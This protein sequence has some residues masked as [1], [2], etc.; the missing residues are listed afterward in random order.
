MTW[1]NPEPSV[2]ESEPPHDLEDLDDPPPR[3]RRTRCGRFRSSMLRT[4]RTLRLPSR[5]GGPLK[6][7][8]Q[9][10]S[11]EDSRRSAT[12]VDWSRRSKTAL[13]LRA[14][15][16]ALLLVRPLLSTAWLLWLLPPLLLPLRLL[17]APPLSRLMV[18]LRARLERTWRMEVLWTLT[19]DSSSEE[20]EGGRK[21]MDGRFFAELRMPPSSSVSDMVPCDEE[22]GLCSTNF[23]VIHD[24]SSTQHRVITVHVHDTINTTTPL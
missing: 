20:D 12:K 6:P 18:S 16:S 10:L 9:K 15:V 22:L 2:E 1:K 23:E 4:L 11:Q 24:S 8:V 21:Q 19:P 3:P 14:V 17:P 7:K 5:L 13:S